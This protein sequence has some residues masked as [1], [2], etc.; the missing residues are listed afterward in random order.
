MRVAGILSILFEDV[1]QIETTAY[2]TTAVSVTLSNEQLE[3]SDPDDYGF[4]K[5]FPGQ[6]SW[7][8]SSS[9]N[10]VILADLTQHAAQTALEDL[11]FSRTRFA[12]TF[13]SAAGTTYTGRAWIR[14]LSLPAIDQGV[15]RASIQFAGIGELVSS[16][17]IHPLFDPEDLLLYL[18]ESIIESAGLLIEWTNLGSQGAIGD[19]TATFPVSDSPDGVTTDPVIGTVVGFTDNDQS[20][21]T[22]G[23][24][25][26]DPIV[27]DKDS[28]IWIV[29]KTVASISDI[30]RICSFGFGGPSTGWTQVSD[31]FFMITGSIGRFTSPALYGD[32]SWHVFRSVHSLVGTKTDLV[33]AID[34]YVL[35][36]NDQ[37][38]GGLTRLD[39]EAFT[40]GPFDTGN[41]VGFQFAAVKFTEGIFGQARVRAI[42]AYLRDTWELS[43]IPVDGTAVQAIT[44]T[45][46]GQANI[47]RTPFLAGASSSIMHNGASAI[48][49]GRTIRKDDANGWIFYGEGGALGRLNRADYDGANQIFITTTQP[50]GTKSHGLALNL[51]ANECYITNDADGIRLSKHSLNVVDAGDAWTE[52]IASGTYKMWQAI[53]YNPNDD[54]IY[55]IDSLAATP[56]L[57]TITTAGASDTL[58]K[59]LTAGKVYGF[60]VKDPDANVLYFTNETDATIEKYD[61]GTD[62]HT[63]AWHTPTNRP[64]GLDIQ[65]GKLWYFE[66]TTYKIYE[67]DLTTPGSKTEKGD[68]SSLLPGDAGGL[69][70]VVFDTTA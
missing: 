49:L 32:S 42:Y 66:E 9:Y 41:D 56:T 12:I 63:T 20:K 68:A 64:N 23:I 31:K 6:Q 4:R 55:F 51:S 46:D 45:P 8:A 14:S 44:G 17:T 58:V 47:N 57:R 39:V 24:N 18:P 37:L 34:G 30:G 2:A 29:I 13:T 15:F 62:T 5:F 21:S 53:E 48:D 50:T 28:E 16:V 52:L 69:V 3:E 25:V 26:V 19:L 59:S 11:A 35:G 38:N 70:V 7:R 43:G 67:V 1:S 22:A 65:G 36:S 60:L 27:G 33:F 10:E 54:L 40:I 61:I